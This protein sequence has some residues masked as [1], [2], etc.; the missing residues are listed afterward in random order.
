MKKETKKELMA[1]DN[2]VVM[3]VGGEVGGDGRGNGGNK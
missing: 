2:R 3:V 1:I